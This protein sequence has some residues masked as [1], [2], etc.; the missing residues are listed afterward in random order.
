MS[1]IQITPK[2]DDVKPS[3]FYVYLHRRATDGRVFYVGKGKGRRAWDV[4]LKG[5]SILWRSCALKNGVAVEICQDG[6]SEDQAFLLEMWLIAK[7][8]HEFS[9]IYNITD[10]GDGATGHV[11]VN[12][13]A[14]VCS[15]GL[16]FMTTGKAA[17]W[18]VDNG[19]P[20]ATTGAISNAA[21]GISKSSFGYSWWYEGDEPVEYICQ[22]SRRRISLGR[23]VCCSNGM[24]FQSSVEAAAW[25]KSTGVMRVSRQSIS[26]AANGVTSS[27]CGFSWWFVGD[28]PK[29]YNHPS[30]GMIDRT[31]RPVICSNGNA[32]TSNR[33]AAR[34]LRKNGWPNASDGKISAAANG[35]RRSAYGFLWSFS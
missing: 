7:F 5:R 3:G 19:F 12:S 8:R 9:V 24:I 10:G 4:A 33:E 6:M 1:K 14:V 30:K 17:K 29:E 27:S 23:P 16:T 22:S 21:R 32:F 20:D 35:K 11:P 18:M 28:E 13:R 25:V 15:N 34:W 26:N 31:S 2:H